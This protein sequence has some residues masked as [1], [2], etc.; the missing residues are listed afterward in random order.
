M[1]KMIKKVVVVAMTMMMSLSTITTASAGTNVTTQVNLGAGDIVGGSSLN[2]A[3]NKINSAFGSNNSDRKLFT[4]P[5]LKQAVTRTSN[6][7]KVTT[8]ERMT[9][10][11]VTKYSNYLL[12]S[13][14]CDCSA[15]HKSVIFVMDANNNCAYKTTLILDKCDH[16]GGI[17]CSSNYLWVTD[18]DNKKIYPFKNSSITDAIGHNY[19]TLYSQNNNVTQLS[20][21][22]A[23]LSYKGGY[24]YTGAFD[25][26]NG[27][28]IKRYRVY[29]DSTSATPYYSY[30]RDAFVVRD[31][32]KIQGL[33]INGSNVV[34]TS[35]Y[36]RTKT[37]TA[38]TFKNVNLDSV[39][40]FSNAK[41][42]NYKQPSKTISLPNMLEGCYVTSDNVY[43]VYESGAYTYRKDIGNKAS[44]NSK[45]M[46]LDKIVRTP[47]AKFGM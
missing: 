38:Y 1:R 37:S 16:V 44:D 15:H 32:K 29:N 20:Y 24:L 12:V 10:Q 30:N 42:N 17:A 13:A 43:T 26:D 34:I 31:I 39:A 22:P 18:S 14:Y 8:C 5:G 35:S 3:I 2:T 45:L 27:T 46:P 19:W 25:E 40:H 6:G 4:M 36:G 47:V 9:P 7:S 23:Y 11:A 21:K 28:T 41:V 33:A